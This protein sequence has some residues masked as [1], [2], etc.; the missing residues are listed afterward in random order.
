MNAE[1]FGRI[2]L[3][4]VFRGYPKQALSAGIRFG[5]SIMTDPV[6]DTS[7]V[8]ETTGLFTSVHLTTNGKSIKTINAHAADSIKRIYLML[9]STIHFKESNSALS[10]S[11]HL[12]TDSR[13]F[14]LDSLDLTHPDSCYSELL[15]I[16]GSRMQD[17]P[18]SMITIT[19]AYVSS[20]SEGIAQSR[21]DLVINYLENTW[22][23]ASIRIKVK[24]RL[25]AGIYPYIN[26]TDVSKILS[27]LI[28]EYREHGFEVSSINV[29]RFISSQAGVKTWSVLVINAG[30]VL[31]H[32]SSDD[33]SAENQPITM[34][35]A[36][37]NEGQFKKI[38]TQLHVIDNRGQSKDAFDTL[39]VT[40]PSSNTG[41]D[42]TVEEIFVIL[43]DSSQNTN[44]WST[45]VREE[46]MRVID[47]K[48]IVRLQPLTRNNSE[49]IQTIGA[50]FLSSIA[51]IKETAKQFE[52][53]NMPY[54][55][56]V[57]NNDW[58][59]LDNA[60]ILFVTK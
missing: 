43:S 6:P 3:E 10:S 35:S 25:T 18:K 16:I 23:I 38:I 40:I 51:Q 19:S 27:P 7:S 33:S 32:Y 14:S 47:S 31:A 11:L 30:N 58:K 56:T 55:S 57:L 39:T 54:F 9:P 13:L 2:D 36:N 50:H 26:F 42:S 1:A 29:S 20:E 59:M 53:V 49:S 44:Q 15:N 46:I 8:Q 17:F 28:A 21:I 60:F 34:L 5:I 45:P 22:H 37:R 48:S 4:E 52:I 41:I 12:L 24:L